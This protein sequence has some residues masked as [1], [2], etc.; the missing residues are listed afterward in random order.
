MALSKPEFPSQLFS[1]RFDLKLF[2]SLDLI[3]ELVALQ[4]RQT[5]GEVERMGD[6]APD[7]RELLKADSM[8]GVLP[9]G[10]EYTLRSCDAKGKKGMV[11]YKDA[12]GN[13][14]LF[15][16]K[17]ALSNHNETLLSL[18]GGS[19]TASCTE[20]LFNFVSLCY[21]YEHNKD[22]A[23]FKAAVLKLFAAKHPFETTQVKKDPD[24]YTLALPRRMCCSPS[25]NV[26]R[27]KSSSIVPGM[28]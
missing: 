22:C 24:T 2:L 11:L 17:S 10:L 13:R 15:V 1:E 5:T 27:L 20:L 14:A 28:I 16:A 4:H 8:D 25:V 23:S 6:F 3:R 21:D 9:S 18:F 26:D 12:C 19:I 7:Y